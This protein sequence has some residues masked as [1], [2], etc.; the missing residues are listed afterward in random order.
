V[1]KNKSGKYN[2][3]TFLNEVGKMLPEGTDLYVEDC[4]R[5]EA[6]SIL[7]SNPAKEESEI[8]LHAVA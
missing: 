8:R 6:K 7:E 4:Y 1:V 3:T 2:A 5:P